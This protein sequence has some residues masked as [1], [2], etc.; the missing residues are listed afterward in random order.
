[1]SATGSQSG[2]DFSPAQAAQQLGDAL[3][4][5]LQES[6]VAS[7]RETLGLPV[8]GGTDLLVALT[9]EAGED[10]SA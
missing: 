10:F 4:N 2:P 5:P 7:V 9:D 6:I 1:M 3:C 8:A